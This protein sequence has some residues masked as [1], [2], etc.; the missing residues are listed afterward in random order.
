M[1]VPYPPPVKKPYTT[2]QVRGFFLADGLA[3]SAWAEANGYSRHAVYCVLGGQFKGHR[4][5]AHEIALKLGLKL[6]A[7]QLAAA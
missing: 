6:S 4:G 1:N 2:D 7:R 3:L 5:K